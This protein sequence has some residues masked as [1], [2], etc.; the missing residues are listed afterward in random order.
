MADQ[1]GPAAVP[2]QAKQ[3]GLDRDRWRWV[4]SAVWTD[5]MLTALVKGV[6][7]GMWFSLVDKVYNE[8]NLKSAW[9][10]VRANHGAAGVDR[11]S[12]ELFEQD[13]A[14]QLKQIQE[15]LRTGSYQPQPVRRAWIDKPGSKDKRPL[16]I[17]AVRDRV[18]QTA[19]RHVL[20]PIWENQFAEHSYGYRPGRDC[21]DALR[22]VD[23][24][25]KAGYTWIV[26]ADLQGFF[27]TIPHD[28]LLT[29]VRQRVADGRVL[30]LIQAYLTAKVMDGPEESEPESGS[31]QGSG[32]SPLLSNIYLNPVDH[33]MA[34]AGYA[35]V[36]YADD[37]VILC[38]TQ[39]EAEQALATIRQL[40][41][42]RGLT[43]HPRKTSVV[44]ARQVGGFDF[45]GYHFERDMRWPRRQSLDKLKGA[46]WVRTK[47]TNGLSLAKIIQSVNSVLRGWFGYFKHSH[48]TTFPVLDQWIR[49]R[50]RS[51]LRRREG[52]KG[53][54]RGADHHRWPNRFFADMGLY[55]LT[56]AHRCASQFR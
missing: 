18:V 7:G 16:G 39:A 34:Q 48:W 1:Q 29:E 2:V 22:R 50:L 25:L 10:K 45:L 30:A 41:E 15:Q 44:D 51:I 3:A 24:L 13:A 46:I 21:K 14:Y 42:S 49:M 32:I 35:M 19:L 27:D 54:G 56:T 43:L 23:E 11:Q 52:R 31:P 5:R 9:E 36:R 40:V 17:P 26:D 4:E 33:H 20:E 53:R 12:V 55:D 47:R 6:K 37:F 8:V 38:R 28:R